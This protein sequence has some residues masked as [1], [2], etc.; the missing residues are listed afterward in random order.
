MQGEYLARTHHAEIIR[1]RDT[2]N[3][4]SCHLEAFETFEALKLSIF[5]VGQSLPRMSR[6]VRA[7]SLSQD[8]L[9]QDQHGSAMGQVIGVPW[10]P[11]GLDPELVILCWTILEGWEFLIYTQT[12]PYHPIP[13]HTIPYHPIPSHTIPY[14]ITRLD[15]KSQGMVHVLVRDV[16][17]CYSMLFDVIRCYSMLFVHRMMTYDLASIELR[18]NCWYSWDPTRTQCVFHVLHATYHAARYEGFAWE[19]EPSDGEYL[20]LDHTVSDIYLSIC[21]LYWYLSLQGWCRVRPSTEGHFLPLFK[22]SMHL[23]SVMDCVTVGQI[24]W[25]SQDLGETNS[26]KKGF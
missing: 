17:R 25:R 16:I 22:S 2:L 18:E 1:H 20:M 15:L 10:G 5:P 4:T 19:G 23:A 14:P 11:N 24:L 13:S 6:L 21:V 8:A 9:I 26:A 3:L 12:I 7:P